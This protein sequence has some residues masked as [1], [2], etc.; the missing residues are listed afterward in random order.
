[1]FV[2]VIYERERKRRGE[3]RSERGREISVS[4]AREIEKERMP[5]RIDREHSLYEREQFRIFNYLG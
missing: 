2:G 3:G 4:E 5:T 1:M